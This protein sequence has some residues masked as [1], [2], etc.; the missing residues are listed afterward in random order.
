MSR[1]DTFSCYTRI[2]PRDSLEFKLPRLRFCFFRRA[3]ECHRRSAVL[4]GCR[5]AVIK[6]KS[7]CAR[8]SARPT[9]V[10]LTPRRP[11]K[12][13]C[14][15][16]PLAQQSSA[17]RRAPRQRP[18][19]PAARLGLGSSDF[20]M[21]PACSFA[22]GGGGFLPSAATFLLPAA[23]LNLRLLCFSAS[24]GGV[25]AAPFLSL[26]ICPPCPPGKGPLGAPSRPEHVATSPSPPPPAV[27][28]CKS[29]P[30][31]DRPVT[32]PAPSGSAFARPRL[33]RQPP[34]RSEDGKKLGFSSPRRRGRFLGREGGSFWALP[35]SKLTP[36][37]AT[38]AAT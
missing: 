31:S 3:A 14:K 16:P 22:G 2:A 21:S 6:V 7:T 26:H 36:V 13:A 37:C 4:L 18:R 5:R 29:V 15:L 33:R 32:T 11:N 28:L 10:R 34:P 12:T 8:L 25:P 20:L 1:H 9:A 23:G 27:P 38:T 19:S 17:P 35:L 24:P 30:A